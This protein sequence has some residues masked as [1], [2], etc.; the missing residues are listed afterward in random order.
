[1]YYAHIP[2]LVKNLLALTCGNAAQLFADVVQTMQSPYEVVLI[3]ILTSRRLTLIISKKL[4]N[5]I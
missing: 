1:M 5:S 3:I 4:Q 2:K